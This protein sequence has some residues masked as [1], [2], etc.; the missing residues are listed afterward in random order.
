MAVSS[1]QLVSEKHLSLKQLKFFV[2]D[3]C[4]KVLEKHG[5]PPIA[6]CSF[7]VQQLRRQVWGGMRHAERAID[8]CDSLAL[9]DAGLSHEFSAV[10]HEW[11][12]STDFR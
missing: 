6:A 7:S 8:S 1:L 3:E 4:D 10:K 12:S 11:L 2:I 5:E 9:R